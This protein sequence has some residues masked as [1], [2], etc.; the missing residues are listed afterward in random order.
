MFIKECKK[1]M[2]SHT[3]TVVWIQLILLFPGHDSCD[4]S[5]V[6]QESL[7]SWTIN[8]SRQALIRQCEYCD[9]RWQHST[10]FMCFKM[11]RGQSDDVWCVAKWRETK[12]GSC[13]F[14]L[15]LKSEYCY[16]TAANRGEAAKHMKIN[17]YDVEEKKE[18]ERENEA[19]SDGVPSSCVTTR[20]GRT[21]AAWVEVSPW[22]SY[23]HFLLII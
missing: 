11:C 19:D 4:M 13:E 10:A 21:M 12:K 15:Y 6:D 2:H 23:N 9:D 1:Q 20:K 8:C 5:F 14:R 18:T 22:P 7:M 17:S 16:V 3:Q